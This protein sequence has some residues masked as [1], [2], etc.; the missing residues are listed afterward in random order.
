MF[1]GPKYAKVVDLEKMES[2]SFGPIIGRFTGNIEGESFNDDAVFERLTKTPFIRSGILEI[3]PFVN[4]HGSGRLVGVVGANGIA[5]MNMSGITTANDYWN[6]VTIARQMGSAVKKV[7]V[8]NVVSPQNWSNVTLNGCFSG[9]SMLKKATF[10]ARNAIK[11]INVG[12][13]T[14]VALSQDDFNM[15]SEYMFSNCVNLV[16]ANVV[17]CFAELDNRRF[18]GMFQ[19]CTSL[20]SVGNLFV[21]DGSLEFV[22]FAGRYMFDGC[23]NLVA[24][25]SDIPVVQNGGC[26]NMFNGCKSLVGSFP[27]KIWYGQDYMFCGCENLVGNFPLFSR[28]SNNMSSYAALGKGLF[29]D[30][31]NATQNISEYFNEV[32]SNFVIHTTL[33]DAFSGCSNIVGDFPS[34]QGIYNFA[35]VAVNMQNVFRGCEKLTGEPKLPTFANV[36]SINLFGAFAGCKNATGNV[37]DLTKAVGSL[38]SVFSRCYKIGSAN[39]ITVPAGVTDIDY[40]FQYCEN[41]SVFPTFANNKNIISMKG[42]LLG[43]KNVSADLSSKFSA[44]VNLVNAGK[45][46]AGTG[47]SNARLAFNGCTKLA[48]AIGVFDGCKALTDMQ[49]TFQG[50]TLLAAMPNI[51]EN[52]VTLFGTFYG[53]TNAVGK[54]NVFSNNVTNAANMFM[55]SNASKAKLVY[56]H[57][58]TVTATT[59]L[60]AINAKNGVTLRYFEEAYND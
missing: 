12:N 30:C 23:V 11:Y 53:C 27:K 41:V 59:L 35:P 25:I 58:N 43:C 13:A 37:P 50:C 7:K 42:A 9:H 55:N 19:G 33:T 1:Y 38:N 57:K 56:V 10:Y 36:S 34:L 54:L 2:E 32:S 8:G 26:Q 47:V 5:K 24:D 31:K 3:T 52:V 6:N 48:D 4:Y 39:G 15:V 44:C 49:Q 46:F 16:E 60:A 17:N 40:A 18:G 20:K 45:A 29:K 22:N 21:N 14:N 28:G 51:P